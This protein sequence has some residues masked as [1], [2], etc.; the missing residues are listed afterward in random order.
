[1]GEL[2]EV[3]HRFGD[4]SALRQTM[5]ELQRWLYAA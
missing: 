5:V 1:M 4:A 2:R 3:S